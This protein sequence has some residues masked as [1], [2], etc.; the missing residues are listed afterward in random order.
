[1][2]QL[3]ID[4]IEVPIEDR[5]DR[6]AIAYVPDSHATNALNATTGALDVT[7]DEVEDAAASGTLTVNDES[8]DAILHINNRKNTQLKNSSTGSPHSP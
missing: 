7:D 2:P 6:V 5:V 3:T 1:M 8:D 4:D